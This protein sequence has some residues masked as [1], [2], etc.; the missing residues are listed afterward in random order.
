MY[1]GRGQQE[2][3]RPRPAREAHT[4]T[5]ADTLSTDTN[6]SRVFAPQAQICSFI[7]TR[8]M[9]KINVIM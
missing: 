6:L 1:K 5:H 9:K 8:Q 4:N 7:M 2:A 3:A